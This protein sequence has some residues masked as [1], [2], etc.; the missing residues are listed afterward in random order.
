VG[1]LEALVDVMPPNTARC[2]LIL[3][4]RKIKNSTKNAI[5]LRI[6]PVD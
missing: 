6:V 5:P 4:Y 1:T 3:W 2:C